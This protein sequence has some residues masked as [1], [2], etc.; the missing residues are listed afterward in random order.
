MKLATHTV[1]GFPNLKTSEK[2]TEILA[3]NSDIVELQIPFS[4]PIADGQTI[5]EANTIA[6]KQKITPKKCLNFA[7]K[8]TKKF[9][10]T[11]FFLMS[12]FNSIF[13]FGIVKFTIEA[14]KSGIR[15]FVIPDLPIEEA[16]ELLKICRKNKLK[17]IFV[18]APNTPDSRLK[19]IAEK[20]TGWI[21]ATARLGITGSTSEFG[22]DLK[23]FLARIRKF[24]KTEI[25]VGFGV[26]S[27]SD[28]QKIKK[29]GGSIGIVGSELFR[30]F[31]S[32]GLKKLEN[33]LKVLN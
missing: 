21:Y 32:G 1:I 29:A 19:M 6:L 15:G 20:S 7:R 17:L 5:T 23:K 2:I 10:S 4:D 12:Y 16:D 27:K 33:F 31:E 25:G 11:D 30:Q 13:R 26:K 28:L 18:V 22:K 9:P 3:K 8:F 14:Q 24:S